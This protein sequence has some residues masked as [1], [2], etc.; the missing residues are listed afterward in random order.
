M[1]AAIIATG[2]MAQPQWK[3][4]RVLNGLRTAVPSW[5]ELLPWRCAAGWETRCRLVATLQVLGA[6]ETSAS[7]PRHGC[8]ITCSKTVLEGCHTGLRLIKLKQT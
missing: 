5:P 3:R 7:G 8:V 4:Y 6:S 2:Y 1:L